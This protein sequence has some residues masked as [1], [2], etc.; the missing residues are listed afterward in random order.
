MKEVFVDM[1]EVNK[2]ADILCAV[3]GEEN[4]EYIRQVLFFGI[5]AMS[6]KVTRT[7]AES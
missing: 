4:R 2:M 5:D 1:V 7:N 3:Y 6:K